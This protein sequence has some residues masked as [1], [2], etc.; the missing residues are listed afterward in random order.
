M[1]SRSDVFIPCGNIVLEGVLEIPETQGQLAGA[2][3]ICHPHPLFGGNMHNNVVRA[4]KKAAAEQGLISLRFN[5]R[6]TGKSEGAYGEGIAEVEDVKAALDFLTQV[7]GVDSGRII[8]AGYSFGCW[9]GLKAAVSDARPASLVGISPPVNEYDFSFLKAEKRPKLLVAGDRDFVC[10]VAG[11]QELV[12][13]LPE[14][15]IA[16]LLEGVDHFH[17]GH[18]EELVREVTAF[19]QRF[20][21]TG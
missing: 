18:E 6:G 8:V 20:P 14:P 7:P 4:L 11:F 13:S 21:L 2:A 10:S 9:V 12:E 1:V 19:L 15:K 17:V 16:T 3:V 5:F